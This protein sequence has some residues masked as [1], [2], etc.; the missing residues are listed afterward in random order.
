MAVRRIAPPWSSSLAASR[1]S[2]ATENTVLYS[3]GNRPSPVRGLLFW[4]A[5]GSRTVAAGTEGRGTSET[6]M[7]RHA[8][9]RWSKAAARATPAMP[10]PP[11]HAEPFLND[12][13][14]GMGQ[15]VSVRAAARRLVA[16]IPESPAG[17]L[18]VPLWP[19]ARKVIYFPQ[20]LMI[21]TPK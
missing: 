1:W 20:W 11:P 4:P 5:P 6:E 8:L 7:G 19:E 14:A 16:H 12:G 10:K 13:G 3:L 2:A 18:S 9:C 17:V 15:L 21:V